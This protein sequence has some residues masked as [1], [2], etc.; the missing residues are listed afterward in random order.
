MDF[1]PT[2]LQSMI[3]ELAGQI[4]TDTVSDDHQR[5]VEDSDSF[6]HLLWDRLVTAE[7]LGVGLPEELGGLGGG[8]LEVAT[9]LEHLGSA[10]AYVPAV[11]TLIPAA[12]ALAEFG[13]ANAHECLAGIVSGSTLTTFAPFGRL[14]PTLQ[15]RPD[16]S[17]AGSLSQ[18]PYWP[19]SDSM[20]AVA[21]TPNGPAL[22]LIRKEGAEIDATPQPTTT[23]ERE[24]LVRVKSAHGDLIVGPDSATDALRWIERR[25]IVAIAALQLGAMQHLL[26]MTADYTVTRTQ[27]GRPIG[28][29]QAVQQRVADAYIDVE[30]MRWTMWQAAWALD[31][32]IES[33]GDA[34]VAKF[35]ASDGSQR[36]ASACLHLHGGMGVDATYPLRRYY[37]RAKQWELSY[38]SATEQLVSLGRQFADRLPRQYATI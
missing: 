7:L 6:D 24:H 30:A 33:D 29:F 12:A 15:T 2:E 26:R 38:G 25:V 13:N 19:E 37:L 1:E 36:I 14:L 35:W 34:H 31:A 4:V 20:L 10:V 8:M 18:V 21:T 5:E 23:G 22:V 16:G 27:F 32:G 17:V 28:S 3:A 9:L 11:P